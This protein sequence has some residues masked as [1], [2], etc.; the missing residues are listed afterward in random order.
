MFDR[1]IF[2]LQCCTILTGLFCL[3]RNGPVLLWVILAI[4]L[5]AFINENILIDNIMQWWGIPRNVFYNLYALLDI[6]AWSAAFILIYTGN[7]NAQKLVCL[8]WSCLVIVYVHDIV[9]RGMNFLSVSSLTW[10]CVGCILF[11]TIYFT[12]ILRAE[13]YNLKRQFAFWICSA[14]FCFHSV[15][16]VNLLTISDSQYWQNNFATITFDILQLM[17]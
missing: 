6:T 7:S 14:S 5:V 15:F 16:L 9:A 8:F 2:I 10:F 12:T 4:A 11:S 17:E 3:R 1:Y 13:Y